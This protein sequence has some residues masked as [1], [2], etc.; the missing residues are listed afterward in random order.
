MPYDRKHMDVHVL[1]LALFPFVAL[2][3]ACTHTVEPHRPEAS[4]SPAMSVK[5]APRSGSTAST[6][7]SLPMARPIESDL[8][9]S[10]TGDLTPLHEAVRAA[11]PEAFD[12]KRSPLGADFRWSFKRQ[13]EPQISVENGQLLVH[14]DYRGEIEARSTTARACRLDPLYPTLDW[15]GRLKTKQDGPN[16]VMY[17]EAPEVSVG[18]KPESDNKC[19]MFAMPLKEQLMELVN[20]KDVKEQMT[21]AITESGVTIPIHAAWEQLHGPYV[22]PVSSLNTRLCIYPDPSQIFLEPV[23]GPLQQAVLRGMAK[24]D[25]HAHLNQSCERPRVETERITASAP[26]APFA[27]SFVLT[28]MLPVPYPTF[29]QRLQDK[30]FHTQVSLLEESMFGERKLIIE[31]ASVQGAGEKVLITVDTSGYVNGPIYFAGSPQLKGTTVSVPDLQMDTETRRLLDAEKAGLWNRVDHVLKDKVRQA[32]QIDV[33]DQVTAV[34]NAVAGPHKAKDFTLDISVSQIRPQ[35]VYTTGEGVVMDL[36]LEGTAKDSGRMNAQAVPSTRR[37][38][39]EPQQETTEEKRRRLL[40]NP[41][42]R[43]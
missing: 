1:M 9:V 41:D 34:K 16:L 5:L 18:L 24:V 23:I 3:T 4:K 29:S 26:S 38:S 31:K 15:K 17:L 25:A 2:A 12:E 22:S 36:L 19:N 21:Q 30:L 10:L 32:A 42:G 28:A 11:V 20:P 43:P 7:T 6:G 40:E 35:R 27:S 14:A 13:G 33:G 39:P 8:P 37:Q